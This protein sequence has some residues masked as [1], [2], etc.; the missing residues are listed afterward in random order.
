MRYT[1]N[2]ANPPTII[3]VIPSFWKFAK[4]TQKHRDYR[5]AKSLVSSK[6]VSHILCT[7][8]GA[9]NRRRLCTRKRDKPDKWVWKMRWTSSD[10][11]ASATEDNHRPRETTCFAF[12]CS[13]LLIICV[14]SAKIKR[15]R[16]PQVLF[17]S[18]SNAGQY[19]SSIFAYLQRRTDT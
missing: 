15:L 18:L 3:S 2:L 17:V 10:R 11:C 16:A 19:P 7:A 5:Q 6:I 12:R 9:Q 8:Q 1:E 14:R 13:S 4:I